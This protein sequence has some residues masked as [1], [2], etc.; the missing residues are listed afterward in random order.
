MP[1]WRITKLFVRS[2]KKGHISGRNTYHSVLV[3]IISH[4][5]PVSCCTQY[6]T[7]EILGNYLLI[8]KYI[9]KKH[10]LSSMYYINFSQHFPPCLL[11]YVSHSL[12]ICY[13]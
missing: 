2:F 9:N 3:S 13:V 6:G 11:P 1:R 5:K 8:E 12:R 7:G 10:L 4:H